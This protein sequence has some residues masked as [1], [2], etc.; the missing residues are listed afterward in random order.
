M[1][2][3][4]R[5]LV[6]TRHGPRYKR[7]FIPRTNQ[8]TCN[9]FSALPVLFC[10]SWHSAWPAA[11]RTRPASARPPLTAIEGSHASRVESADPMTALVPATVWT[12][13]RLLRHV[14]RKTKP[15]TT[16][17]DLRESARIRNAVAIETANL[18]RSALITPVTMAPPDRS[19]ADVARIVRQE[20]SV[21]AASVDQRSV[22]ARMTVSAQPARHVKM[23]RAQ[24]M[25]VMEWSARLVSA[26]TE[27]V[28]AAEIATQRVKLARSA[29]PIRSSAKVPRKAA[30]SVARVPR[31]KTAARK[32]T[33]A[34]RLARRR[35]AVSPATMALSVRTVSP[36]YR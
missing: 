7:A 1:E 9:D 18:A 2:S 23:A 33:H 17:P 3:S 20:M 16:I 22:S 13:A 30:H 27:T 28:S 4:S 29:T 24:P 12:T 34:S 8:L 36:V 15:G 5:S 19:L 14:S 21:S 26:L 6:A 35:F 32:P 31:T 11:L 25:R 10:R